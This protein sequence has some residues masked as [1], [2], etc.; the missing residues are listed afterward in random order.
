MKD[1][2]ITASQKKREIIIALVCLVLAIL[3]NVG[4]V[5]YYHTSAFELLS[6]MG[7]VV[8]IAVCFYLLTVAARLLWKAVKILFGKK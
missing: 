5:I 1:T 6:Q 2:L 7:F 8:V 4:A 3:V